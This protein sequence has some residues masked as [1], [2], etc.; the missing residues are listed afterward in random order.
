MEECKHLP[1]NA[2][3]NFAIAVEVGV[4]THR[5]VSSSNKF[6]TRGVDGVV[7]GAAEQEEEEATLIWRVKGTCN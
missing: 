5:V 6:D 1:E 4:E 2:K 3:A 7:R